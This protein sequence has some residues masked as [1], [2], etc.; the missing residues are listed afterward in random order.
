MEQDDNFSIWLIEHKC[1]ELSYMYEV[2][3]ESS[4]TVL[5]VLF[6]FNEESQNFAYLWVKQFST[7]QYIYLGAFSSNHRKFR[8]QSMD[9][10]NVWITLELTTLL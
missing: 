1:F 4:R 6:V 3:S 7:Q 2:Q 10:N 9:T 5:V 8:A